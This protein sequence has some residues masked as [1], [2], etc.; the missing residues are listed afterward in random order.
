M[1]ILCACDKVYVAHTATMLCSLLEHNPGSRIH[2]FHGADLSSE[3]NTL[4]L[5]LSSY[6]SNILLYDLSDTCFTELPTNE[7]FSTTI[8]YRLL[9][10]YILPKNI[11]KI[12]YLDSDLVVRRPLRELW[13]IDLDNYA[14]AAVEDAKWNPKKQAFISVFSMELAPGIKYFNSG[15]MLINLSYWKLNA[16][17]ERA[18]AFVKKHR[19]RLNFWDQDALNAV[20]DGRW[21]SLPAV[22]NAHHQHVAGV[23]RVADPAIVHYCGDIKPWHW[24]WHEVQHPYKYEYHRYRK[25]TP[26]RRYRLEGRPGWSRRMKQVAKRLLPLKVRQRLRFLIARTGA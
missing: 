20:L 12:L 9:A 15:V 19:E 16:V 17:S 11:N 13:K 26:W 23:S 21:I 14:L 1:E 5:F 25:R 3:L 4:T 24:R 22:W 18:I 8:Y 6:H 10:P 2:M 7:Y